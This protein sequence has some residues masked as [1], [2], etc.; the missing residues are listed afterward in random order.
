M[1]AKVI[2]AK[3]TAERVAAAKAAKYGVPFV[4]VA[5]PGGGFHVVKDGG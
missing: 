1:R 3:D 2:W 4:V 5:A